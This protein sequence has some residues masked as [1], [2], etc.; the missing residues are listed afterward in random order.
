M[1]YTQYHMQNY[2]FIEFFSDLVTE[3]SDLVTEFIYGKEAHGEE[4]EYFVSK[5]LAAS[6]VLEFSDP[7]S[8]YL[9]HAT[10]E[11]CQY[12]YTGANGL[13]EFE[14]AVSCARNCM[15]EKSKDDC[16]YFIVVSFAEA[17][18]RYSEVI[19]DEATKYLGVGVESGEF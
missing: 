7:Q 14:N 10:P 3:F 9:A 6:I 16:E 18:I 8:P 11:K 5:S 2:T 19:M 4:E 17:D 15:I 13:N 1:K 12:E